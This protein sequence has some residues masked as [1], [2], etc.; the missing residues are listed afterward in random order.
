MTK[1]RYR[2]ASID[3][4]FERS[5][6]C[7]ICNKPFKKID[8]HHW[9]YAYKTGEVRD[10]PELVLDHTIQ[11]CFHC[12]R[13]ADAFRLC[14]EFPEKYESIKNLI[15]HKVMSNKGCFLRKNGGDKN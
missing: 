5:K 9:L 12:H 3:V 10:K 13:V 8:V 14:C 1:I 11:V 15:H 4:P 6:V 2:R 7:E